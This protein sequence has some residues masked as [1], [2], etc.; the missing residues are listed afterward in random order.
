M[1]FIGSTILLMLLYYLAIDCSASGTT[2]LAPGGQG[3]ASVLYT[4]DNTPNDYFGNYNAVPINSPT[5]VSPGYNG[6]GYAI[7]LRRVSSQY[8]TIANYLNFYHR[9]LT[10]EAWVYPFTIYTA[11]PYDD[12]V[13]Y[14]QTYNISRGLYMCMLLR[15]GKNY[16]TFYSDDIMGSTMFQAYRW[17]HMAFTYDYNTMTQTVYVNGIVGN[18]FIL[19][20]SP[21]Q[22]FHLFFVCE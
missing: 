14:G 11:N 21:I 5:Y 9:S 13:I 22:R 8:L 2:T 16:G 4:F 3:G 10:V 20:P 15:N 18:C 19:I 6:R 1:A 12:T 17:Q 7:Q